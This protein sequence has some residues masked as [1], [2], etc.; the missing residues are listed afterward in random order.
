MGICTCGYVLGTWEM[1]LQ[2]VGSHA[3]RVLGTELWLSAGVVSDLN[4]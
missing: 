1:E 2:M 4:H 3:N